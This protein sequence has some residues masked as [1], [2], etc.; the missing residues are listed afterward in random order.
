MRSS[1]PMPSR[2]A[3]EMRLTAKDISKWLDAPGDPRRHAKADSQAGSKRPSAR[4]LALFLNVGIQVAMAPMML[5]SPLRKQAVTRY[6]WPAVQRGGCL[7]LQVTDAIKSW[8]APRD[9]DQHRLQVVMA[10]YKDYLKWCASCSTAEAAR[11][12]TDSTSECH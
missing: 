12:P 3:Q 1:C 7:V 5:I 8:E 2:C 11:R 4:P 9:Q 6:S 10:N